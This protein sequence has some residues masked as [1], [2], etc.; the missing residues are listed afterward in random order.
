MSKLFLL[1]AIISILLPIESKISKLINDDTLASWERKAIL[2]TK[3]IGLKSRDISLDITYCV[4]YKGKRVCNSLGSYDFRISDLLKNESDELL[5][6]SLIKNRYDKILFTKDDITIITPTKTTSLNNKI[7]SL[8]LN[9]TSKK[10][11]AKSV[12]SF[13][14]KVK[15]PISVIL[16]DSI[17]QRYLE[18]SNQEK[19]S[20]FTQRAKSLGVPVE[21]ISNLMNSS[22]AFSVYSSQLTGSII[23]N[24]FIPKKSMSYHEMTISMRNNS[25]LFINRLNTKTNPI[26]FNEYKNIY[27]SSSGVDS[28]RNTSYPSR[29]IFNKSIARAVLS[30][31][32]NMATSYAYEIVKDDNFAIM[33]PVNGVKN[34]LVY[35]DIGTMEDVRI[36]A[37]YIV[38][39]R[40]NGEIKETGF[41]KNRMV[42]DNSYD[43]NNKKVGNS[44]FDVIQGSADII[45]Q[46]KEHP[47]KGTFFSIGGGVFAFKT[48]NLFFKT[49][50]IKGLSLGVNADLG[51]LLN[52]VSLSEVWLS[53][54]VVLGATT[55]EAN[56][57][58]IFVIAGNF[59]LAKRYY[60]GSSG[61]YVASA[62]G[63]GGSASSYKYRQIE[64]IRIGSIDLHTS[65]EIGFNMGADN[66]ISL[67]I[68]YD[69]PL[70]TFIEDDYI[71]LDDT[72][73]IQRGM[74][75]GFHYKKHI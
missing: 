22:F 55:N 21:I 73:L 5:Y 27:I 12:N 37:P 17:N 65:G 69:M 19:G 61:L 52:N 58:S 3:D 74:S 2:F 33:A 20:F 10:T 4:P 28:I 59:A 75:F 47:W 13:L 57:K 45:S 60:L 23:I 64:N 46:L 62:I 51:Y 39:K 18:M 8:S 30:I 15:K 32:K 11:Y 31:Y 66:E 63:L 54:K 43:G 16:K 68:D 36:D 50:G 38:R 14:D 25:N 35:A 26:E 1:L 44:E 9:H 29:G 56:N 53:S 67:Y 7:A 71:R 49:Q 41:V 40:V 34:N 48:N 72:D 42:F 24:K 70:R 6:A